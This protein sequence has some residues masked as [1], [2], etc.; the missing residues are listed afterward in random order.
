MSEGGDLRWRDRRP[1]RRERRRVTPAGVLAAMALAI[2]LAILLTG[3]RTDVIFGFGFIPARLHGGELPPG[4]TALP[5]WLTPL[6]TLLA[7]DHP[8]NMIVSCVI[9]LFLGNKVEEAIGLGGM[10]AVIVLGAYAGALAYWLEAPMSPVPLTA[11][12]AADSPLIGAMAMLYGRGNARI[13]NMIALVVVWAALCLALA[14]MPEGGL[15]PGWSAGI[16]GFVL[17]LAAARPLLAWRYR[18]A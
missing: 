15:R 16:G 11:G 9:L 4:I 6:G 17:G 2:G 7:F 1:V 13:V 8:L 18:S 10:L 14:L 3:Y 5:V 12:L